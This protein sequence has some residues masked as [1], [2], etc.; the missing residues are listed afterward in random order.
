MKSTILLVE[1]DVTIYSG[2]TI[3]GGDTVI[4]HGS[5]IGGNVWLV[6]SV[7]PYSKVYNKRAVNEPVV[8]PYR[9]TVALD[10]PSQNH[11]NREQQI[12]YYI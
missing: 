12:M 9:S 3:L 6:T 7:P 1:D 11:V 4:G 5:V 2:T 10:P 8:T